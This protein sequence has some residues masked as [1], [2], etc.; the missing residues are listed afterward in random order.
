MFD[1]PALTRITKRL[2]LTW[3]CQSCPWTDQ[4]C[5]EIWVHRGSKDSPRDVQF[6]LLHEVLHW[7]VATDKERCLNNLGLGVETAQ[8]RSGRPDPYAA[9]VPYIRE[10]QVGYLTRKILDASKTLKREWIAQTF[11]SS[12][13][14]YMSLSETEL[15]E[16]ARKRAEHAMWKEGL[17]VADIAFAVD[18][19]AKMWTV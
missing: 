16:Y 8:P 19:D 11:E 15:S 7:I 9:R 4:N 5:G 3:H 1:Y 13:D 14:R 2:G 18:A 12:A 10:L 17:T 6:I